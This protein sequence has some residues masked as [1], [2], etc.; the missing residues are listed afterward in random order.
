MSFVYIH[1]TRRNPKLVVAI[2]QKS[3]AFAFIQIHNT[4][5]YRKR[6]DMIFVKMFTLTDFGTIMFYP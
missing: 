2:K 5:K 4:K 6:S 1:N 3:R